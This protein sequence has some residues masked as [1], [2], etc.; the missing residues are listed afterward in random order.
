MVEIKTFSFNVVVPTGLWR[1]LINLKLVGGKYDG[2]RDAILNSQS[3][4]RRSPGA[5][6]F[7]ELQLHA[8]GPKA[9]HWWGE[10]ERGIAGVEA[11]LFRRTM[12]LF[13]LH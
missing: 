9:E 1:P 11:A 7:I 8:F 3:C 4:Q 6:S 2:E 10:K 13:R 12:P 5:L